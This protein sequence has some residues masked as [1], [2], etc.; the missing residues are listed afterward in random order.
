MSTAGISSLTA[1]SSVG[2]VPT[3]NAVPTPPPK[4]TRADLRP[5]AEQTVTAAL[6]ALTADERLVFTREDVDHDRLVGAVVGKALDRHPK[7]QGVIDVLVGL[8]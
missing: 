8:Q 1:L 7:G 3:Q 5:I 6:A 2:P 4:C